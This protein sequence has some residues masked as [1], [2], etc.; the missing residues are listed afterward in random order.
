[1]GTASK[2][3]PAAAGRGD[4]REREDE[5]LLAEVE[6]LRARPTLDRDAALRLLDEGEVEVLGLIHGSSNYTF[7]ARVDDGRR[8]PAL[9]VYK[10]VRGERPLWDFPGGTLAARE[11]AAWVVSD[12][13]GWD[14]VPP[15]VQREEAPL[16]PGSL[17][18]FIE[19]DPARHYLT[20]VEE[21]PFD[22]L[23]FAL[24]DAV[25]NNADRKSGHV[26]EARDG[27]LWAVD[28]GVSFHVEPKLRTV[29]WAF[30]DAPLP[31][32]LLD[33][34]ERLRESL[35]GAELRVRLGDLLDAA[36][37]E[38]ARR[39]VEVLLRVRRFP[40]PTGDRPLPWP[41]V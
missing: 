32:P 2:P 16:G 6:A 38:A 19:H 28:H 27:K 15:T 39:R 36:E 25:I 17:Q 5:R 26:L 30:A 31:G 23:V 41:L 22:F 3:D 35:A 24:F 21:R 14:L 40:K 33:D 9:A 18:Q 1:M 10:P 11:V 4:A 37:V 8:P 34:L 12:Q 13:V 29:I 20:L 7:L